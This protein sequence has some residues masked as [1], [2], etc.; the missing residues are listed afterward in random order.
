MCYHPDSGDHRLNEF[1]RVNIS[2]RRDQTCWESVPGLMK[3]LWLESRWEAGVSHMVRE[4]KWERKMSSGETKAFWL[5]PWVD[6]S[7]FWLVWNPNEWDQSEFKCIC[8]EK[9]RHRRALLLHQPPLFP[10]PLFPILSGWAAALHFDEARLLNPFFTVLHLFF[11][12]HPSSHACKF[13]LGS[14]GTQVFVVFCKTQIM[15]EF[16]LKCKC[17]C[18]LQHPI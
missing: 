2:M 15:Q 3:R 8:G 7:G 1:L 11:C 4:V 18:H 17:E 12:L 5:R 10:N 13:C 14:G 16:F 6:E 9:R